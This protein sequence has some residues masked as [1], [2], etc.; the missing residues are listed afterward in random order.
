MVS[1]THLPYIL[2]QMI[3]Y[4]ILDII[5]IFSLEQFIGIKLMLLLIIPNSEQVNFLPIF[6]KTH[7]CSN[8]GA[9]VPAINILFSKSLFCLC[10]VQTNT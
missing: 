3:F 5:L 7:V 2:F 8:C 9:P 4:A 1:N 6:E 10:P